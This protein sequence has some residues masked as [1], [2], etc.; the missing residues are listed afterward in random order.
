MPVSTLPG[1]VWDERLSG[2]R[3]RRLLPDGRLGRIVSQREVIANLRDLAETASTMLGDIA[4]LL[5]QGRLTLSDAEL[6]GQMLLLDFYNAF[7]ALGRGGWAQMDAAAYQR[8]ATI[9]TSGTS[10]YPVAE[11]ASWRDFM[12]VAQTG[13][14]SAAALRSRAK[15]YVGKAYSR[16]WY[17]ERLRLL[18]DTNLHQEVWLAHDDDAT[19]VDC[20]ALAALGTV[21]LGTLGTVPGA[22]ATRCLGNCRC[23]IAYR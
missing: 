1:Y 18:A 7:T 10:H 13:Q 15:L 19:C 8:T 3:Y 12:A 22:G 6:A 21:P 20:Q 5:S 16:Y 23:A 11:F 17:E 14:L 4:V 2:G 9:L